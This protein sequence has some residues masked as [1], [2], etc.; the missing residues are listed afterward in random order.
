[1]H[2]L[3]APSILSA[4]MTRLG[5]EVSAV[6]DAGADMIHFDVMDN[7]YV[8]NLTIG[9][10]I[11]KSLS[12]RFPQAV[13]DVHLMANPVD[14]L[15]KQF[16]DAGAKRISIHPDGTI[17][18]DRSLQLIKTLGCEAGLVLNPASSPEV[19]Q[20][21]L[22]YLDFILVMTVNPGFAGQKLI[23]AVIDKIRWLKSNY[24]NLPVCVDGG[25]QAENIA[26]LA[27]AGATQFV[28]GS[29]IFCSDNYRST[30]AAMRQQ[31]ATVQ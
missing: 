13:I 18:L 17:H 24:P 30:I 26:L 14:E 25:V 3:I 29:A 6:L 1:M 16:A 21:C 11:C 8:P 7:H 22:H 28:A 27:E 4:D 2:Y 10:F 9:P 19:I 15:I 20:W 31:L 23:P 12:K 5:E